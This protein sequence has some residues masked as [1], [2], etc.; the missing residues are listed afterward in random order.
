MVW[1]QMP[2][3]AKLYE[4]ARTDTPFQVVYADPFKRVKTRTGFRAKRVA[5][6]FAERKDAEDYRDEIN[7]KLTIEGA[8]GVAFDAVLRADAIAARQWLDS[9]G[10]ADTTLRQLAERH[11]RQARAGSVST[12]PIAPEVE[13]FLHDKEHVDGAALETVKN[14]KTRL[15]L[16]IDLAKITCVGDISRDAAEVLRKRP[17]SAQTRRNDLSAA[18]DF[19]TW[20]VDQRKLDHHPLKGLKRPKVHHGKKPTWTAEECERVLAAAPAVNRLATVAVMIFAGPRPSELAGTRLIYGR[21]PLV[22][23]EDGKLKGRANRIIPMNPALR[24]F[25]AACGNPESVPALTRFEREAV[26]DAARVTWKADVH[27]HTYISNRLQIVRKDAEVAREGGT[28]EGVI[29]RHY[30]GLKTP[31][32]ARKWAGI[33]PARP[34]PAEVES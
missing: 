28:S 9:H 29:F 34:S 19:C 26:R 15:W 12:L 1:L 30:H 24:A 3:P 4:T 2:G 33:R 18:S 22:R 5:K 6:W 25:L 17:V 7:E 13:Q 32:E 14:L 8:A 10:H 21:H 16:W 11:T 31:A 20:L 27:R 23:I